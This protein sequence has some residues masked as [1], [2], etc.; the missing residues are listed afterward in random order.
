MLLGGSSPVTQGFT[1]G[2]TCRRSLG[3][4]EVAMKLQDNSTAVTSLNNK[5]V[6]SLSPNSQVQLEMM[7]LMGE[8]SNDGAIDTSEKEVKLVLN[9]QTN[10]F[11]NFDL[12]K[13]VSF[14]SCQLEQNTC[15]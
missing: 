5:A 13:S 14:H 15:I 7:P 3:D 9:D 2:T 1:I 6:T 8:H 4:C 11:Q 12:S 10:S